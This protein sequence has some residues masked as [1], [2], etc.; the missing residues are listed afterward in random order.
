MFVG[1]TL[2]GEVE[3]GLKLL[4]SGVTGVIVVGGVDC[5]GGGSI[6]R[7]VGSQVG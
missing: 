4:G 6:G 2:V 5:V 7:G 1:C 3:V